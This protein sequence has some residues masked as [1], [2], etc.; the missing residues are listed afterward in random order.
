MRG[1]EDFI[2]FRSFRPNVLIQIVAIDTD[3]IMKNYRKDIKNLNM[4]LFA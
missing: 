4:K 1:G 3:C 2:H